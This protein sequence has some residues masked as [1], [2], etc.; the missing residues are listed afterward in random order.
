MTRQF[1]KN[2]FLIELSGL[3]LPTHL[4][5]PITRALMWDARPQL[6]CGTQICPAGVS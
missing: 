4:A 3:Y 2:R 1:R 5:S 6:R